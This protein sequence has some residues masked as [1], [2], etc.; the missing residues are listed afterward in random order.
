MLK[1]QSMDVNQFLLLGLTGLM[2]GFMSGMVGVGGGIIMVP[3]LVYALNMDQKIAQGTS[4]AVM[5]IPISIGVGVWQYYKTGN[6]NIWFALVI[7]G[8]FA[9]GGFLGSK[10]AL[11]I[12]QGIVKK[13][14]AV[15][16]V[17]VAVKMFFWK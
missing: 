2:A 13:I 4:L 10:L 3:M 17:V 15:L 8:F 6:V 16:M 11:N 12:D 9:V 14:F 7:A 1:K 5:L